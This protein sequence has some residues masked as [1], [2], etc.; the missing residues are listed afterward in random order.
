MIKIFRVDE[1]FEESKGE[2]LSN[3]GKISITCSLI[4]LEHVSMMSLTKEEVVRSSV[5]IVYSV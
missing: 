2:S 3:E 4:S 5:K 1:Y